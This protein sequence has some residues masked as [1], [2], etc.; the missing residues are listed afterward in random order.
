MEFSTLWALAWIMIS[1]IGIAKTSPCNA[2]TG[3]HIQAGS[4][5]PINC[6]VKLDQKDD[7]TGVVINFNIDNQLLTS[8]IP[9]LRIFFE[10]EKDQDHQCPENGPQVDTLMDVIVHTDNIQSSIWS[11]GC[12]AMEVEISKSIY[13]TRLTRGTNNTKSPKLKTYLVPTTSTI[14]NARV[15]LAMKDIGIGLGESTNETLT[16][17]FPLVFK[18]NHTEKDIGRVRVHT[19]RTDINITDVKSGCAIVTIQ[20]L[21]R[22][23]HYS[24]SDITFKSL[25]QTMLGRSV[26]DVNVGHDPSSHS[27]YEDGFFIVILRKRNETICTHTRYDVS[28]DGV[29]DEKI[30]SNKFGFGK[31]H[32]F[33]PNETDV[34]IKVEITPIKNEPWFYRMITISMIIIIIVLLS[35]SLSL[36]IR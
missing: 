8:K 30:F 7:A 20:R 17:F 13:M 1:N 36:P 26:I 2:T 35:L 32:S 14:I 23:F 11:Y 24:E 29:D 9:I 28:V 34:R 12:S 6:S 16:T 18:Y 19:T 15:S 31:R 21:D 5:H 33:N 4:E 22:P 10:I 3:F 27:L 25:W